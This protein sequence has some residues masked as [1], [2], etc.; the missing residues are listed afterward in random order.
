LSASLRAY[1]SPD[2]PGSEY[3]AKSSIST[4]LSAGNFV[5]DARP[6]L[7]SSMRSFRSEKVS[8]FVKA[9]L[10]C[11]ESAARETLREVVTRY[12]IVATR[13]L[14]RAKQWVRDQARGS[15]QYGLVV[16][17]RSG[18]I[19]TI[20]GTPPGWDSRTSVALRRRLQRSLP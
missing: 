10:D 13:D 18:V 1:V 12:P 3:G 8:A 5:Q 6:H 11:D 15:E 9:L 19:L 7:S 20:T 2:L 14:A 4:L 16:A 17:S